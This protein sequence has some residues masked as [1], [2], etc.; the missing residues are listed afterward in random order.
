MLYAI[1]ACRKLSDPFPMTTLKLRSGKP[2]DPGFQYSYA[3]LRGVAADRRDSPFLV[4]CAGL[5]PALARDHP[6]QQA[7]TVIASKFRG[8]L[9]D[10]GLDGRKLLT[11]AFGCYRL[12]LPEGTWVDLFAAASDATGRGR[13]LEKGPVSGP[14]LAYLRPA[15]TTRRPP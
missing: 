5:E 8:A 3:G 15:A 10:A 4:R 13:S 7:L 6:S 14:N 2:I 12:D 11:A 9:A 1:R